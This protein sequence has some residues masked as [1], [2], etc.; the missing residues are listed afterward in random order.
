MCEVFLRERC[1]I[2]YLLLKYMKYQNDT[3]NNIIKTQWRTWWKTGHPDRVIDD[4]R[5]G[6]VAVLWWLMWINKHSSDRNDLR[7]QVYNKPTLP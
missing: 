3:V 2:D 5:H 4:T 7:H 6:P 1:L